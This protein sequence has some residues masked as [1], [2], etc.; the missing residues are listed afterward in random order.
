M[1][2]SWQRLPKEFLERLKFIV[3]V[4]EFHR[5][6][7]AFT[8]KKPATIRVNTLK[9]SSYRLRRAM[10]QAGV[11]LES[12]N[13]YQDAF[14]VRNISYHKLTSLPFYQLGYFYL[15]NLSSMTPALVISPKPSEKILDITAA[16]G[17]KTTQMAAAMGNKGEIVAN[18]ISSLRILKMKANLKIQGVANVKIERI[19]ARNIWQK[20]LEYFDATLADVPCSM[21][22]RFVLSDPKSFMSWSR[23]KIKNLSQLQR[24][25]LR[26]AVSATKVGGRIVYST[27]TL[28]PEENEEVI[29]WILNKEKNKV[30]IEDIEIKNLKLSP[31]ITSWMGKK[32]SPQ[33][34]KCRRILPSITMEGFFIAL[35]RKKSSNIY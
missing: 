16:P 23:K 3:P 4:G 21:E 19:D 10:Q 14:I 18:D 25:I 20:Y 26:S 33:I 9:I 11:K 28:S 5:V 24:W 31:P 35:L 30:C 12:V 15:Q 2:K 7:N 32:Y 13:W 1:K 29:D 34:E 22:G 6:V 17:S 8:Y 27:C